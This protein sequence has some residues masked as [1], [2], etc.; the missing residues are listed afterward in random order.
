MEHVAGIGGFFF[1]AKDPKGLADWYHDKLGGGLI[2]TDGDHAPWTQE[3]GPTAF[4]PFAQDTK[5][6][7]DPAKHWK[8][9][10]ADVEVTVDVETYPNGRFARLHD[11][12][13]NPV[14]LWQ[15][16]AKP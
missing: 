6:F 7:G 5:H 4:A 9:R 1:R 2:P 13:G 16:Q 14:E 11:P 8:L 12:G 10:T 15:P 3:A